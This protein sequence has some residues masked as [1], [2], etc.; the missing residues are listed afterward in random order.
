VYP[1]PVPEPAVPLRA[2]FRPDVQGLRGIAVLVVV[3]FHAGLPLDGGFVGVDL[4]FVI[5]GY[6][7]TRVLVAELGATNRLGFGDFYARRARRLLPAAAMLLTVVAMASFLL[8]S[9]LRPFTMKESLFTGAASTVFSANWWLGLRGGSYFGPTISIVSLIGSIALTDAGRSSESAARLAFYATPTRVW[10]FGA[11][12]LLV[13]ARA[14]SER[15][16]ARLA[17]A[18]GA[19]GA[20]LVGISLVAF[21]GSTSFPGAAALLPVAG[22]VL[23]LVSG[24]VSGPIRSALAWRPLTMIGDVSYGWYLWHWPAIVF[25]AI[26]WTP[27][28]R[29]TVSASIASLTLAALS[30]RLVEQ[31]IRGMQFLRGLRAAALAVVCL[32]VP[33]VTMGAAYAG[34]ATGDV[35]QPAGWIDGVTRACQ[36]GAGTIDDWSQDDCTFGPPGASGTVLALGD[37]MAT[38][39]D[40]GIIDAAADRNLRTAAWSRPGCPFI[41]AG[42]AS[43][44]P[45]CS[46]WQRDALRL[47]EQLKPEAVVIVNRATRYSLDAEQPNGYGGLVGGD[48]ST[49]GERGRARRTYTDGLNRLLDELDRLRIPAVVLSTPPDFGTDV[50]YVSISILR[51]QPPLPVISRSVLDARRQPS[52]DAERS[53]TERHP[54]AEYADAFDALCDDECGIG[55]SS[56]WWYLSDG[57]HLNAAGSRRLAGPVG[58]ALDKAMGGA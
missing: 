54:L 45:G 10:E 50:R 37:S 44:D 22:T 41:L 42:D 33:L 21:D 6:V 1:S 26:L 29:V 20:V 30:H 56:D 36:D 24:S 18:V 57:V 28:L 53:V 39:A 49:S 35:T 2:T 31:R 17:L 4:F 32:G 13:L 12:A 23:L 58:T 3:A 51:R 25:A 11:G 43:K 14:R 40:D 48:H 5:S 34:R 47:V 27:S 38:A 8:L 7:I 16:G 46:A 52:T 55:S 19:L 15:I 9:P